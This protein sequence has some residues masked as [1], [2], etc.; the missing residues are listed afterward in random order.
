MTEQQIDCEAET[1]DAS[2]AEGN[3]DPDTQK[4]CFA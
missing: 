3:K 1:E 2:D 4:I